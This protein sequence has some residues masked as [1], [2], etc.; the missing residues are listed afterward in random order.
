MINSQKRSIYIE[1]VDMI[2]FNTEYFE[3]NCYFYIKDRG[4]KISLYY[5]VAETLTE[6]RKSDEKIDFDKKDV[7]KVKSIVS[8]AMKTKS[9]VTKKTLDKKLKGIKPKKE[10]DELVDEDGSLLGSRIPTYNQYLAPRK[11]MDQT[12][13]MA[14]TTNDPVMRGYRVYYGEGKESSDSVIN[15]IDYSEAF[16]YDETKDMD[17]HDTVKT[18]KKMGVENPVE[19][20]KQFGKLPKEEVEDGELRQRLSEKET[21]EERQHRLMKKMVEDI[22]T[23][24]PKTDSDVIKNTG[25]SKILKK[26]LKVIKNIA[27][28]EG[29]SINTLIKAL[30]SSD[31][32]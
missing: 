29:I 8:S 24:K 18:L 13:Q 4:D 30:K 11:T 25:V 2:N 31:D 3:N 28:K 32:E 15:E 27:D 21:L 9:K 23:K 19:R 7:K 10:I 17:Y 20:A 22:L 26:N 6:S 12:V 1:K 16:G 5:N 14:R